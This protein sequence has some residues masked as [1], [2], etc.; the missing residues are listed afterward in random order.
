[1][2]VLD[3]HVWIWWA[4]DQSRLSAPALRAIKRAKS[5]RAVAAISTWEIAMLVAKG[6]IELD[7]DALG[8]IQDALALDK[9]DLV[10]LT[11]S[12]A[13]RSSQLGLAHG[14]PADRLIAATAV[15]LA[16]PLVTRDERLHGVPGLTA[17]W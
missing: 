4:S 11:P 8:W 16:C 1:M 3:T 15:E 7:R 17:V 6:R 2:I 5:V 12:I 13:V 9:V 14:D 10:P